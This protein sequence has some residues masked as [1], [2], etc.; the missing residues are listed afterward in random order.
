MIDLHAHLFFDE[1]R[2][3]AGSLG[4]DLVQ[5][6]ENS[7]EITV[8]RFRWPV[9]ALA[10]LTEPAQRRVES[11]DKDG[12]GFQVL[13]LSPLWLLTHTPGDIVGP[14][15]RRANTLLATWCG[16]YPERIGGFAALPTA[17]V[18]L[19]VAELDHAVRELGLR[20]AYIGTDARPGL[21]DPDLDDLYQAC[22]DLDVPLFLHS[23]MSG[24][25][26]PPGDVRLDRFDGHVTLGYPQEESLAVASLIFGK[27]LLRHPNL[28]VYV[29]HGG[30]SI[31]LLHG[32]L[33]R[34]AALPRSPISV[35]EFDEQFAR[36]WFDTHLNSRPAL[37]LLKEVANPDR[38]VFGTNYRGWDGGHPG[39]VGDLGPMLTRNAH[40]LLRTPVAHAADP[41]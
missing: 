21:D 5:V 4:P 36:L 40:R 17:D 9:G 29:S 16:P 20:G 23:T 1:L 32:R 3:G 30:G 6:G 19:A 31:A 35:Q 28:D 24:V 14:F 12:I 39:E 22:V 2:G 8:G 26:G 18:G 27:V 11:L 25:D 7:Y 38:L 37:C 34:F 33:R 13:S 15:L 41:P 10:S